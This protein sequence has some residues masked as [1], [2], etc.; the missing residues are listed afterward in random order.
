MNKSLPIFF[1]SDQCPACRQQKKI[2]KEGGGAYLYYDLDKYE[3]PKE[4]L[5][6]HGNYSM[7]TWFF[8]TSGNKGTLV[9]GIQN[10]NKN[11]FGNIGDLSKYGKNF[12]NGTGFN[13]T[14][15]F[16]TQMKQS[17]GG[18]GTRSGTYGR[19]LGTSS[20]ISDTITNSYFKAPGGTHPSSDYGT[21]LFLNR[22]CNI[23]NKNNNYSD[24][25][26]ISDS[27]Y[28]EI[29]GTVRFG[30]KKNRKRRT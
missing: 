19:E 2:L 23:L 7:P 3:V 14:D 4:I 24:V 9:Y 27:E 6:S 12:P 8:P 17:W 29:S 5:D 21:L 18:N 20:D 15:T 22:N 10:I 26:L 28:N 16:E 30:L 13:N 25:G 11:S 1:G